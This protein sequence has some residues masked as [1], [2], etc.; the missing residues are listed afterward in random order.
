VSTRAVL[1]ACL[2]AAALGLGSISGCASDPLPVASTINV[3]LSNPDQVIANALQT[4][5]TWNPTKEDSSEAAY[6]R[7]TIYLA[8]DLAKQADGTPSPGPGSQWALWRA[9]GANVTA[10]V[11]FVADE[12]PPNTDTEVHRVVVVVQSATTPDG[13]LVSEIRHTA[14][15]TA[16][17][18]NNGW[19]VTSIKF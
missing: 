19:R 17:K 1:V 12:T 7:A 10:K 5:F 11:Y 13:R 15:V 16:G 3:D 2:A 9:A 8:G 14:W 18:A 6:R 4:M